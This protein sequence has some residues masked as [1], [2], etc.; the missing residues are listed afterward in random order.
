MVVFRGGG[1]A[2]PAVARDPSFL[3]GAQVVAPHLQERKW[4]NYCDR[5][6]NFQ[7][8]VRSS[9]RGAGGGFWPEPKN[10]NPITWAGSGKVG[11]PPGLCSSRGGSTEVMSLEDGSSSYRDSGA[12]AASSRLSTGM[13]SAASS[14]RSGCGTSCS[15]RGGHAPASARAGSGRSGSVR[16]GTSRRLGSAGSRVSAAGSQCS[17]LSSTVTHAEFQA[18]KE[19]RQA[20]ERE[21]ASLKAQVA[22]LA[23]VVGK[24]PSG[25]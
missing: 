3:P 4:K 9:A 2:A 8:G 6:E 24:L 12:Y 25:R 5:E 13:S 23:D 7:M 17:A 1:H 21:I 18:E 14:S 16:C 20:A 15:R 22:E 11:L 10:L 19:S